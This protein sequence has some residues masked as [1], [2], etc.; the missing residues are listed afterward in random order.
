C[1]VTCGTGIQHIK[2]P[3]ERIQLKYETDNPIDRQIVLDGIDTVS[4]QKCLQSL[5]YIP[6]LSVD[7]MN[8]SVYVETIERQLHDKHAVP[9]KIEDINEPIVLPCEKDPCNLRVPA[10]RTT[11]WSSVSQLVNFVFTNLIVFC[12]NKTLT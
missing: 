6:R 5:Q 7:K 8:S 3:C 2:I 4:S 9:L 1:S 11:S 12:V 10:W